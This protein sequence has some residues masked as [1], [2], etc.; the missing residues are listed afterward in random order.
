MFG[1][2]CTG[3][4][5]DSTGETISS[6]EENGNI[7]PT[8]GLDTPQIRLGDKHSP[9]QSC[10]ECGLILWRIHDHIHVFVTWMEQMH[11]K[12]QGVAAFG[13]KWNELTSWP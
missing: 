12:L 2:G 1:K 5:S 10:S 13:Y 9:V 4:T 3:R 7:A 11:P 8:R 6:L